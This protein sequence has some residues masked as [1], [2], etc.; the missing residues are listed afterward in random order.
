[1]ANVERNFPRFVD[2]I[3]YDNVTYQGRLMIWRRRPLV[4]MRSTTEEE[5]EEEEKEEEEEENEE[6]EDVEEEE[7]DEDEIDED[8]RLTTSFNAME[9]FIVLKRL[10]YPLAHKAG[11]TV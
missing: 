2:G 6:E 8:E 3:N 4:G 5:A 9:N 10:H 11:E 7:I 1:M